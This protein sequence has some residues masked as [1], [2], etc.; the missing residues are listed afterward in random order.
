[1]NYIVRLI[2]LVLLIFILTVFLNCDTSVKTN[3]LQ[4]SFDVNQSKSKGVFIAEYIPSVKG[5][6]FKNQ[7]FNI[8][9]VWIEHYWMY[10]SLNKEIKIKDE[11]QGYIRL[12][13][14]DDI[15]KIAFLY[16]NK[17][18]GITGNKLCFDIPNIKDTLVFKFYFEKDT[19]SIQLY[20]N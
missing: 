1:M 5:L 12:K 10:E 3:V 6:N 15:H 2:N 19:I 18:N 17:K 16:N 8:Q 4:S 9:Q 20:K 11:K 14:D 13:N 7:S